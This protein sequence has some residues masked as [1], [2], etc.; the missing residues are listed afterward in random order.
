MSAIGG[1]RQLSVDEFVT[2]NKIDIDLGN[3]CNLECP[4]AGIPVD[5]L[6]SLEEDRCTIAGPSDE[7]WNRIPTGV[8]SR[9][10][11]FDFPGLPVFPILPRGVEVK[12][13]HSH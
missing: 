10:H 5:D 2:S 11:L 4:A 3:L 9:I 8:P 7:R 6:R 12:L 1:Q 13:R